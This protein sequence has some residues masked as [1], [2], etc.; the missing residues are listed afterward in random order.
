MIRLNNNTFI[1]KELRKEIM[2]RLK[3][4]RKKFNRNINHETGAILNFRGTT[5]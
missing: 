1:N 2:R 3:K 4:L 5:V